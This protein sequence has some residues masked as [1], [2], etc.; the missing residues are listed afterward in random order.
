MTRASV[1]GPFAVALPFLFSLTPALLAQEPVVEREAWI[2]AAGSAPLTEPMPA[3]NPRD[4][5]GLVVGAIVAPVD[6]DDTW[7]CAAFTSHDAGATW[8][9]HDF[10]MERCIDPW[11]V[12]LEADT[13]LFTGIEL[14]GDAEGAERFRLVS[15][16]S[17]DGG[18]SWSAER[19]TIGRGYD[20]ELLVVRRRSDGSLAEILLAARR[21]TGSGSGAARHSIAVERSS[22]GGRSF[23]P[24]AEIRPSNAAMNATGLAL[25]PA[26][27]PL[28]TYWEFQRDVDGFGR[29]GM[30]ERAR[31]AA[32]RIEAGEPG[33]PQ[34]IGDGCASG[35]E[36]A[37]PGY[38]WLAVDAGSGRFGGR[39]Y[40]A[41]IRPGL[42]GV[43][44]SSSTDG[45]ATWS[46]QVVLRG[47][48][49]AARAHART[50]MLAVNGDGIVVAAWYDRSH[51]PDGACQHVYVTASS[52]GGESFVTPLRITGEES[53]PVNEA[54]GRAGRSWPMGGDY[55]SLAAGPDGD[56]HLVW[57]DARDGAF[58]LRHARL[59][60]T[61]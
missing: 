17:P 18:R 33:V 38:P 36:G 20:H 14:L 9:R 35:I 55:S 49:G 32:V 31:A 25:L 41:C 21:M 5:D 6:S 60:V 52:D 45:G 53:C 2:S 57:A 48:T 12:F 40:H 37:F 11:I 15:Y 42:E 22:D 24:V 61:R 26:G 59:R 30:L 47:G 43:G 56:F 39:L 16:R 8:S 44:V 27:T 28:V 13:V 46:D 10:A 1:A 58:R 50:P 34:L 23:A 3:V 51:D 7:H 54:N 29:L 19:R 4:S